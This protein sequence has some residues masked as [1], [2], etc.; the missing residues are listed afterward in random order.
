MLNSCSNWLE[1][2]GLALCWSVFAGSQQAKFCSRKVCALCAYMKTSCQPSCAW[3]ICAIHPS[4]I[5]PSWFSS[6]SFSEAI[7]SP[8]GR[9]SVFTVKS[10]EGIQKRCRRKLLTLTKSWQHRYGLVDYA[11]RFDPYSPSMSS[12]TFPF[13]PLAL[14]SSAWNAKLEDSLNLSQLSPQSISSQIGKVLL[15]A[16]SVRHRL[17]CDSEYP[18]GPVAK[19]LKK[20]AFAFC[21]LGCLFYTVCRKI[22]ED[23]YRGFWVEQKVRHQV[24]NLNNSFQTIATLDGTPLATKRFDFSA[25][26]QLMLA[27]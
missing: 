9:R 22:M 10:L 17:D 26:S 7:S 27:A 16:Q 24:A 12:K 13:C 8:P 1:C 2:F 4:H 6:C 18:K 21:K 19:I 5:Q 20:D 15:L 3:S 25:F 14:W 11:P 23:H